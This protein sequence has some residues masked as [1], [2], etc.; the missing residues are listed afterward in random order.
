[1]FARLSLMLCAGLALLAI[2]CGGSKS[3]SS[4]DGGSTG[5]AAST[6]AAE[7]STSNAS[8]KTLN[9][10]SLLDP[11]T[12]DPAAAYDNG[13]WRVLRNVYDTL[14]YDKIPTADVA[15][16]IA[17]SWKVNDAGD[18]YT[19]TLRE[20]QTFTDG[21]PLDAK[22]VKFS[23]DRTLSLKLGPSSFLAGV[24]G[25]KVVSPTSFQ[26]KLDAPSPYFLQ[27]TTKIGIVSPAAVRKHAKGDDQA[28]AWL[29][30]NVVGSGPYKVDAFVPGEKVV[31]SKNDKYWGGWDGDHVDNVVIR[32]V[33]EMSTAR[34]LLA[35]GEIDMM[36]N[37]P[38]DTIAAL[39]KE[40]GMKLVESPMHA[41]NF[42]T[43]N[44]QKPP[45]DDVRVRK[46]IVLA[47]PYDEMAKGAYHGYAAVPNGP[48]AEGMEGWD[49]SLPPFKTDLE[50][51]KKLLAEAGNPK[52]TLTINT[53]QGA[54]DQ[55][56]QAELLQS[57][58]GSIGVTVKIQPLAWPTLDAKF[59]KPATAG[60]MAG[61]NQAAYSTDPVAYMAQGFHSKNAG[62]TYN[63]SYLKDPKIDAALDQANKTLDEAKRVEYLKQA[64]SLINAQAASISTVS[65]KYIDAIR[66]NV[67]GY[68]FNPS[69]YYYIPRFYAIHKS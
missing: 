5:A 59:T 9:Y 45:L 28:Q 48:L 61:L 10:G 16:G 58:L 67:E 7:G 26:I 3:S 69:D 62:G 49:D 53:I 30:Q 24:K 37:L 39:A 22:A 2:G 14:T 52:F 55:Q 44:T 31:L 18:T 38:V 32:T 43:I 4:S 19:F 17:S 20:G 42:F 21:T 13:S 41:I 36:T 33:P 64:Q 35:R 8:S 29:K 68:Q 12:L 46:A 60:Q 56:Q 66:S 50:Q 25:T 63:W 23:Y 34:Q 65:P 11:V 54:T 15:P 6:T 47:F 27:K 51:A 1:V 57:S 40:P